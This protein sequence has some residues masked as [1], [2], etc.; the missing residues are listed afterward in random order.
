[1]LRNGLDRRLGLVAT[2]LPLF[3]LVLAAL[4]LTVPSMARTVVSVSVGLVPDVPGINDQGY[5]QLAYEGLL[6]AQSDLGVTGTVYTPTSDTEYE[7]QLQACADDGNDLCI[8]VGFFMEAATLNVAYAN[9][10]TLF[11]IVDGEPAMPP[12]NLRG[13]RFAIDEAGY[14]AG[15]LAGLMTQSDV[16]GGVGG[17]PIPPVDAFLV[18]YSTGAKCANLRATSLL[19][20]T[21]DFANPAVGADFAQRLL[22][23]GAD[24]IF[25]VAGGAGSGALLTTT[26]SGAWAIGVDVDQYYTVFQAG[27]V[28]GAEYLLTSAVNHIDNAVYQTIS[29]VVSGT[30]SSGIVHYDLAD[31][32][33]GLAPFH[34]A[35]ASV[36]QSV[37]DVL[38]AVRQGIL[39]GTIDVYEPCESHPVYLPLV[40]SRFVP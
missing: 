13:L 38:A 22:D 5:N 1:M 33:V 4:L 9:P 37:R 28:D 26:Q 7:T 2:L 30:F 20:Y 10:G 32:G 6:R 14:L 25:A 17:L 21:Y 19:T 3:F 40:V 31:D 36:P 12:G 27:A 23:Q 29:D 24:A 16:V 18:P 8:S 34:E 15:T 11:A 35:D 39:D